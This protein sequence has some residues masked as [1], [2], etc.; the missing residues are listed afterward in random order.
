[1]LL[2]L[3]VTT[4]FVLIIAC[5]NVGNLTLTRLVQ[6][7]TRDVDPRRAR[8]AGLSA[9]PA[10][11]RRE[12]RALGARRRCSA[13]GSRW[14][15]L[16]L[17]IA[18]AG[19]FTNRTGEIG[20]DALGAGVHDAS[21]RSRS[22]CCLRGRRGWPSSNDPARAMAGAGRARHGSTGRRRA[23][24]AAG[25]QSAGGVVHA[26]DRRRAADAHADAALRGRSGIRSRE[27]PE[28]AGAGLHGAEP[29]QARCSSRSDVSSASEGQSAVAERRRW[30]RPRRSPASIALPTRNPRSTAPMPTPAPR[31]R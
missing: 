14:R 1:M 16:N 17:L 25:R 7:E 31:R 20:I 18:Y 29:R 23:Q 24:R 15:G 28:P 4:I 3:L 5:A 12:P 26:A 2:I 11:A 30:R 6:R 19:R 27:R 9:P 21:S 13:S 22:R 8:R 10:T